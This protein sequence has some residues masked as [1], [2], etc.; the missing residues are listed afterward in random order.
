MPTLPQIALRLALCNVAASPAL[1]APRAASAEVELPRA[2]P[3]ARVFQ[4]V[5]LTEV[6]VEY[7][8]PALKGRRIFGAAVPYDKPWTIS[9]DRP[10]TVRFSRDVLVVG[11]PVTAGRYV[12]TAVPAKGDWT[13]VLTRA[14]GDAKTGSP[15]EP[16]K[17]KARTRATSSPRERLTFLFDGAT[18]DAVSLDLEWERVRVSLPIATNTAAQVRAEIEELDGAWRSYANAA[19]YMLETQKDFD[20]G[21]KYADRSLALKEDWYTLWIKAA[22][23]AAKQ[24]FRAAVAQGER[25]YALGQQAGDGFVLEPELKKAIADWKRR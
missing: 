21:L 17:V 19:R 9:P 23:L 3:T 5:G 15:A 13:I 8:S 14:A 16:V 7:A 10:V 4:Q 6:E 24:D 25:A 22:L 12:V 11:K 20:T 18:D 1:L 2:S